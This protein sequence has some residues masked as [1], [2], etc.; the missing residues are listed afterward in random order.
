M[1]SKLNFYVPVETVKRIVLST[2]G[3]IEPVLNALRET[4]QK[5]QE[6]TA[7]HFLVRTACLFFY[8]YGCLNTNIYISILVTAVFFLPCESY[9]CHQCFLEKKKDSERKKCLNLNILPLKSG[10]GKLSHQ[11]PGETANR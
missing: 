1:F 5:K 6:C 11:G 10:T 9:S 4:I 3:V 7:E 2:A 8:K